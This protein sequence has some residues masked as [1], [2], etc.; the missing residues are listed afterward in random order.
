MWLRFT[1][2]LWFAYTA[3]RAFAQAK[4]DPPVKTTLC[5]LV[6]KPDRFH[7]KI[8]QVRGGVVV[9]LGLVYLAETN[10]SANVGV[11]RTDLRQLP[12][13]GQYVYLESQSDLKHL[14]YLNW[15]AVETLAP[16]KFI[17]DESYRTLVRLLD[18][19]IVNNGGGQCLNCEADEVTA[20]VTGRF[21]HIHSWTVAYRE[22]P[23]GKVS[24]VKLPMPRGG[25]DDSGYFHQ[26]FWLILQSVSEVTAKPLH[27]PLHYKD[28]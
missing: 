22:G 16:I 5:D 7:G 23:N 17:E 14:G 24:V 6:E 28:P 4:P 1:L 9:L 10:C 2:A 8:V 12:S 15:K 13:T 19:R 3:G 21:E 18:E 25:S 20:T 27:R 26:P 11:S